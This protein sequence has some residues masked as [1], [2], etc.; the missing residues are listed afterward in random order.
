[1][2]ILYSGILVFSRLS[3]QIPTRHILVYYSNLMYTYST[4]I[5]QQF[6]FISFF[7][8]TDKIKTRKQLKRDILMP[9]FGLPLFLQLL[10]NGEYLNLTIMCQCPSSGYLYFYEFMKNKE[11]FLSYLGVNALLRATF[12]ST[13]TQ[14]TWFI[15][16]LQ[17]QCPSSGYL[18][19][20]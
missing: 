8:F 20:Y 1:M 12:I 5:C 17:C 11:K 4:F 15:I 19:F 18:Y 3:I 2:L 10:L 6:V 14:K 7:L 9:F 13:N 16:L